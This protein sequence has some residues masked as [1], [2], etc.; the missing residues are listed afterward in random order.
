M[1]NLYQV[2]VLLI[3]LM[4]M[5]ISMI[6]TLVVIMIFSKMMMVIIMSKNMGNPEYHL[7]QVLIF[8]IK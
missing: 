5:M 1:M 6:I 3:M 8:C 2:F 7:Y 4:G